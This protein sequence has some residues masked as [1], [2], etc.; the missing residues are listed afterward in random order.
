M[1][2]MQRPGFGT[3]TSYE[4]HYNYGRYAAPEVYDFLNAFSCHHLDLC[5]FF[6]GDVSTVYTLYA[7]RSGGVSGR[8]L[9]YA[10]VLKDRDLSIPQEES[11]L[12]SLQFANGSIGVLQTNCLERVQERVKISGQG[13]WLVV[14]DW[15][16]VTGYTGDPDLPYVWEPNDQSPNDRMDFRTLH[17]YTGEVRHFVESVRDGTVP[18]PNIDD[19]I[20]HLKLEQAAKRSALLG[21]PVALSE[22]S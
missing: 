7:S 15:R 9:T 17:G 3:P 20:A 2:L 13:G 4:A 6:M 14:D 18:T 16:R 19:G 10:E 21:R 12:L 5:R 8:P 1:D 11:W 22:I